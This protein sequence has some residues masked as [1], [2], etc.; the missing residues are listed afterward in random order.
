M[1]V[2]T[3]K[4]QSL[5]E[6]VCKSLA[7]SNHR[8]T[9]PQSALRAAS[10]LREGAGRGAHHSTNRSKTATLRAIFI[11]PTKLGNRFLLPSNRVLAKPE[12]YGR[13][14]SPLRNSNDGSLSHS[15]CRPETARLRAIFIAP[16]KTQKPFPFPV[17]PTQSVTEKIL[18]EW[19]IM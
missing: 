1:N 14:S 15:T 12:G 10:S 4:F 2:T 17:Q 6:L 8:T 3:Q 18:Y 5:C 7:W 16:T 11:A 9:L 13:F 19:G